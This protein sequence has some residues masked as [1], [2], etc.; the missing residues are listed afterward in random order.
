MVPIKFV[1]ILGLTALSAVIA[2]PVDSVA[3]VDHPSLPK[4]ECTP[5]TCGL[6]GCTNATICQG[7]IPPAPLV[8]TPTIC[9]YKD[10][11]NTD[12]CL[13]IFSACAEGGY[14][15]PD[16]ICPVDLCFM[17]FCINSPSCIPDKVKERSL[18]KEQVC[19][20]TICGSAECVNT[21]FCLDIFSECAEGD[22]CPPELICPVD[23][24]FMTFCTN[25]PSCIPDKVKERS[26]DKQQVSTEATKRGFRC[27]HGVKCG[28]GPT[29]TGFDC[30]DPSC[31][32][33]P[34]C[35]QAST[36][37]QIAVLP[38]DGIPQCPHVCNTYPICICLPASTCECAEDTSTPTGT[39][40]E[41]TLI[42]A[43]GSVCAE[44]CTKEGFCICEAAGNCTCGADTTNWSPFDLVDAPANDPVLHMSQN[45]T[46][47]GEAAVREVGNDTK[48]HPLAPCPEICDQYGH[49]G[50]G[51]AK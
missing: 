36:P 11:V 51:N 40:L 47:P 42:L 19:T 39:E 46:Q 2:S 21:D 7:G 20:P 16:L 13:D 32:S 49:C 15:P 29:C 9:G 25:S 28:H 24:C 8:C 17:T 30:A 18:D 1:A 37:R 38:G 44:V 34:S 43:H 5:E 31:T 41:G 14:C 27:P 35:K 26:L 48:P 50:C 10:C 6:P 23:L 45:Y 4:L 12:F 22:Y 33:A 3:V